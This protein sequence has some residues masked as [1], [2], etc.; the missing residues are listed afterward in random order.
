MVEVPDLTRV[1]DL[2]ISDLEVIPIGDAIDHQEI[3]AT[4]D[5]ISCLGRVGGGGD[6]RCSKQQ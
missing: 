2:V 4:I 1:V 6:G 5:L 3:G